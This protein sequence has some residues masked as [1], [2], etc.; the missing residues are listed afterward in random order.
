MAAYIVVVPNRAF[1]RPDSSGHFVLRGL[2]Q[3]R[4]VVNAW[5][6]DFPAI[7]REV[8]VKDGEALQLVIA[9]GS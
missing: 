2:P 1:T 5:H 4:Y 9:L 6:P 8:T 7:R 3:G